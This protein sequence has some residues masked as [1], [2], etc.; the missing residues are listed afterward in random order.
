MPHQFGNQLHYNR[1]SGESSNHRHPRTP[2]IDRTILK[3]GDSRMLYP[4]SLLNDQR[5]VSQV[6]HQRNPDALLMPYSPSH[7]LP[8]KKSLGVGYL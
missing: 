7:P 8:I 1:A 5:S 2:S 4:D 3:A 6:M